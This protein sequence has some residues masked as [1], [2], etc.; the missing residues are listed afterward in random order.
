ML[1]DKMKTKLKAYYAHP[2]ALYGTET[3]KKDLQTLAALGFKVINPAERQ[4]S[5]LQM[6]EFV[7][8]AVS[9]DLV[10][11]RS[12]DD[13]KVG[14]GVFLEVM[15]AIKANKPVLELTP[16]LSGRVLSRN[17]TRQR[18]GLGPLNHPDTAPIRTWSDEDNDGYGPDDWGGQ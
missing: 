3:E 10:A 4:Y 12:F 15:G 14:S 16:F 8:L 17:E 5:T 9:C 2:M 7:A 13:G 18:M 11:F 6:D 1:S